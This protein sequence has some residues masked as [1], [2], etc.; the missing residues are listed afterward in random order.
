MIVNS[1]RSSVIVLEKHLNEIYITVLKYYVSP[2]HIDKE[3]KESY[4]LLI[5]ILRSIA[6]L[7]SLLSI[8]SFSRLLYIIKEDIDKT[9]E[10]LHSVLDVLKD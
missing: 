7:F 1:S 6:I 3:K 5:K 2:K 10:D 8:Y 4:Y 9:L